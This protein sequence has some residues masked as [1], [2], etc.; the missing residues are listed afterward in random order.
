[1][2]ETPTHVAFAR[3]WNNARKRGAIPPKLAPCEGGVESMQ[4]TKPIDVRVGKQKAAAA[5]ASRWS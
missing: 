5:A 3:A 4:D 2:A 1:M